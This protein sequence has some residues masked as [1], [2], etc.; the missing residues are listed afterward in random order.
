MDKFDR[1]FDLHRLL[2]SRRY[3]VSRDQLLRE[4]ECSNATL[5]RTI[6]YMR[7]FL[8]APIEYDR[9][10]NGYYYPVYPGG[11]PGG[12]ER[13]YELPGLWFNPSELY[14]LLTIQH[15]MTQLE[16]GLLGEQL[17][18]FKARI[19]QLMAHQRLGNKEFAARV[20]VLHVAARRHDWK[21]FQA[22]TGATIQRKKIAIEYFARGNAE[23]TRRIV[24]P[25]RICYYRDNWYLDGWCHA[26]EG[27]RTFA[28]D[29]IQSV[30]AVDEPAKN[31]SNAELDEFL[32][33]AYGIFSGKADN[34]AVL[35]FS[36]E[37]A[38][39]VAEEEWHPKQSGKFLDDGR[40]ELQV[41][42]AKDT[43]LIM[44]IGKYGPDVE[45]ISPPELRLAVRSRLQLAL[46]H[47][48][49]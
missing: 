37:S 46:A 39:W 19:E 43:E 38:R 9:S 1:I 35:R 16:P 12:G 2:K 44:E 27:L 5:K 21:H 24:S 30:S 22:C 29:R 26:R 17:A 14:A 40:F 31:I 20:R 7:D 6:S 49:E 42:Y 4:L 28:V 8:N 15:L 33:S 10:R 32:G 18:P 34:L 47:Y 41:P 3:P 13:I 48:Q 36:A 23:R 11:Y 25:Q 45:V